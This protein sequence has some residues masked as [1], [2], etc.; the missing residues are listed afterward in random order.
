MDG[1]P[2][3]RHHREQGSRSK[4]T[5]EAG[6]GV[7]QRQSGR[8]KS[9]LTWCQLSVAHAHRRHADRT[10]RA[11]AKERRD[12]HVRHRRLRPPEY[13]ELLGPLC[14]A[15]PPAVPESPGLRPPVRQVVPSGLRLPARQPRF[16]APPRGR[17][18]PGA[19]TSP[20][21]LPP[22]RGLAWAAGVPEPVPCGRPRT[23]SHDP[24]GPAN[25]GR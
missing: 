23:R 14:W 17:M 15:L 13:C 7:A 2:W 16:Q 24:G 5:G 3:R 11:T 18:R 22:A 4:G 1:S 19:Q 25:G 21:R 10:I 6:R 20:A 8:R 9:R 12:R